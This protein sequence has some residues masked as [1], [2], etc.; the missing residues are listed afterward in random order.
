MVKENTMKSVAR[1]LTVGIAALHGVDAAGVA[2]VL[3]PATAF[4]FNDI[5]SYIGYISFGTLG[6][7]LLYLYICIAAPNSYFKRHNIPQPTPYF[8]LGNYKE[9]ND[10]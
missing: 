8:F 10:K 7:V 5:W 3:Y 9:I 1:L 6:L 4:N 2:D